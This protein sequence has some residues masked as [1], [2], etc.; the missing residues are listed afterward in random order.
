MKLPWIQDRTNEANSPTCASH[1]THTNTF[2]PSN[3]CHT[4]LF[5]HT[6]S[7]N[8]ESYGYTYTLQP[9]DA[10]VCN[11]YINGVLNLT[12][13]VS[14]DLVDD[15]QWFFRHNESSQTVLLTNNSQVTIAPSAFEGDYTVILTITDL[16]LENEGF[17]WCQGLIQHEDHTLELS[18]SDQFKLLPEQLYIPFGCAENK[19]HKSSNVRCAAVIPRPAP[20]TSQAHTSTVELSLPVDHSSTV[21]HIHPTT[22]TPSPIAA[23]TSLVLFPT[24][25]PSTTATTDQFRTGTQT[26]STTSPPLDQGTVQLSDII[27]YAILGLLGCLIVLVGSLCLVIS[28]LCCKKRQRSLEGKG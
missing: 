25:Q 20:S 26:G 15:I 2:T 13:A 18:Q 19:A 8:C 28:V 5:F 1:F 14:G 3:Y 23:T 12:C 11:P 10:I 21:G 4:L 22:T 6:G 16:N 17:Y 7:M 9:P 24:S 27:L